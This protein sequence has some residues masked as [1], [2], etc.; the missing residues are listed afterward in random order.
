MTQNN[1]YHTILYFSVVDTDNRITDRC[2]AWCSMVGI[3]YYRF[4]PYMAT[5]IE[6]DEKDD[7]M[8]IDLMWNTMAYIY[9]RKEDVIRLKE[10]LL[11]HA[12]DISLVT[13]AQMALQLDGHEFEAIRDKFRAV[14]TDGDGQLTRAEL[15]EHFGN[16]NSDKVEFTIKLMDLDNN[17]VIEF[18]EFLEMTAFLDYKKGISVDKIKQFFRALDEDGSGTLSSEEIRKFH[19]VMSNCTIVNSPISSDEEV[20]K[21]VSKLDI[22]GDGKIDCEEFILGYILP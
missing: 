7:K 5:D 18:H 17:G 1:Y 8:L 16:D 11:N 22:N 6:L 3:P 10:I 19:K 21:L 12:P 13:L 15:S 4:N 2:R 20:E 14:D 9:S